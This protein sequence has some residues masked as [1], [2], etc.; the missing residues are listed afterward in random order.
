MLPA[1]MPWEKAKSWPE[2]PAETEQLLPAVDF[3]GD[4]MTQLQMIMAAL[5]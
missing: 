5:L 3:G 2:Q 4:E 1:R